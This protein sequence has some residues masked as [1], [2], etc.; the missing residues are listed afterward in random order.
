LSR[1]IDP[2]PA[3]NDPGLAAVG[4]RLYDGGH[5]LLALAVVTEDWSTAKPRSPTSDYLVYLVVRLAVHFLQSIPLSTGHAACA[6]VSQ[7]DFEPIITPT[8]GCIV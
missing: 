5:S 1:A 8:S 7:S 6:I 4:K 2:R 3:V